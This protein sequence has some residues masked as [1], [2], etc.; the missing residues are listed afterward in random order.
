MDLTIY[1]N[2]NQNTGESSYFLGCINKSCKFQSEIFYKCSAL[3]LNMK[4]TQHIGEQF[5]YSLGQNIVSLS[6]AY[7]KENGKKINYKI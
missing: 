4:G 5:R 1:G 3:D 2:K 6:R 7:A